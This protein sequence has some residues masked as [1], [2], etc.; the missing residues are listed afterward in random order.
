MVLSMAVFTRIRFVTCVIVVPIALTLAGKSARA[1]VRLPG[2]F[3]DHMVFQQQSK[4]KVWGWADAGETV[5]VSIG[6]ESVRVDANN[7]GEWQMELGARPAS[8][9]PLKLIVQAS[10]KVEIND[11]LIGEVWLCSGQSN[12]E[13]PVM[14]SSNP[15]QEIAAGK[16]P[17][18]RH[19]KFRH[20]KS[21]TPTRD[22]VGE[23]EVCS[24]ETVDGFSGVAY[25]FARQL[26]QEL[27]VPIGLINSSWGGTRVEPWTPPVGFSQVEELSDI[28]QQIVNETKFESHQDPTMLYNA[29]IHPIVGYP[30]RGAIWYQGES[31]HNEGMLYFHKKRALIQGWRQLWDQGDFPFYFVQIAPFQYGDEDP[32][33]LPRFLGSTGCRS[34]TAELPNGRD[35]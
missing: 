19:V 7:Q 29:M 12:M 9:T 8:K 31:N 34:T 25:F 13:W 27:D 17:L 33:I 16:Y 11:V 1:E 6:D 32:K 14:R 2:F 35:K 10:N 4:I 20:R 30:I 24:P 5:S 28:H 26:Q 22:I 21:L 23:W 3:G 15:E 18:I